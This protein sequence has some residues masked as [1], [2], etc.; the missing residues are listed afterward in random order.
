MAETLEQLEGDEADGIVDSPS[1]TGRDRGDGMDDEPETGAPEDDTAE[2]DEDDE[3]AEDDVAEEDD[4]AED[5]PAPV[6]A[7]KKGGAKERIEELAAKRREAEAAAFEAE[8][9]LVEM[10]RQLEELRAKT[11]PADAPRRPDP[12]DFVYGETDPEYV[13]AR[14]DFEVGEKLRATEKAQRDAAEKA[15]IDRL[16]AHYASRAEEVM[17]EGEKKYPGFGKAVNGLRLDGG[18]VQ[19]VLDSEQAVDVTH[20]LVHNLGDLRALTQADPAQRARLLGRLEGRLSASAAAGKRVESKAP[21]RPKAKSAALD[22]DRELTQE[23][24]NRLTA[25]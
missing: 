22:G 15:E 8:M 5:P 2:V 20:Y 7:K 18:V 17:A 1:P 12:A 16:K 9:K 14:I 23:E 6:A 24:V 13:Q 10:Q 3:A 11:A 4:D 19:M 25:Y 21:P